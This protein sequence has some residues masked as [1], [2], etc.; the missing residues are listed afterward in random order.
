MTQK[1][2]ELTTEQELTEQEKKLEKNQW[3]IF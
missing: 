1:M 3:S 2:T